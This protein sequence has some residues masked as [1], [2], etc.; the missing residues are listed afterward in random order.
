MPTIDI[1]GI[2]IYMY[3]ASVTHVL[4]FDIHVYYY[5]HYDLLKMQ[6][7]YILFS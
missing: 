3:H 1:F 7:V 6:V 2:Y 5:E 4:S